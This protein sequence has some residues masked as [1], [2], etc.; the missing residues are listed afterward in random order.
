MVNIGSGISMLKI[1]P[2]DNDIQCERVGGTCLGGGL[3]L[4]LC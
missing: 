2:K 1:S 4:G 3:F